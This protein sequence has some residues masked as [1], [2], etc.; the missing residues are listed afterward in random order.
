MSIKVKDLG[1]TYSPNTPNQKIALQDITFDV[2]EGETVGI[3]GS[4][5]SGKSTLIQHLNGLIKLSSGRIAVYDV[6]L[7][8]KKPDYRKVRSMIGMLFQYPEYQLFE[9]TVLKD[10]MFAPL[11]FGRSK[12]EAEALAKY[13]LELV[14]LNFDEI[15][16]K[17]P[18]ELSGGQKRRVAI[19]GIIAVEPAI[20]VLDEPTAGLD[21]VG[22]REMLQLM[23][24]LK[25]GN[26]K[27]VIMISHNMEEIAEF[28][29]R[30]LVLNDSKL[31]MDTTPRE[32][33]SDR[34]NL[35]NTGLCLPHCAEIRAMLVAQGFDMPEVPLTAIEL[36]LA[37]DKAIGGNNA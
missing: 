36:A 4:T 9:D 5:G 23:T 14:G 35:E 24:S 21:P 25:Q 6:D 28:S 22:K 1:F 10:V 7:S 33:F 8:V 31:I 34:K 12:E 29:D 15:K 13:A 37:I 20:L 2:Q 3:I 27:I 32:L 18:F 26:T 11:N 16:D 19:A 17:S 30:I